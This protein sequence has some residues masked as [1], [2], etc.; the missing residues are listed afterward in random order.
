MEK[1]EYQKLVNDTTPKPKKM[2]HTVLAFLSGGLLGA[3]CE[4][5]KLL[6]VNFYN[7]KETAV[8]QRRVFLP[9]L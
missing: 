1:R 7:I 2:C 6:L 8:C 4:I 5:L 9:D 3:V